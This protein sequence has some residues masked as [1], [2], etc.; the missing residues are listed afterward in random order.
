[1][2]GSG[3]ENGCDAVAMHQSGSAGHKVCWR[4]QSANHHFKYYYEQDVVLRVFTLNLKG[5]LKNKE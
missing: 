1:M 4:L 2:Q 5:F 3:Y